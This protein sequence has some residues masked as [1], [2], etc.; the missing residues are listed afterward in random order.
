MSVTVSQLGSVQVGRVYFREL[1][2]PLGRDAYQFDPSSQGKLLQPRSQPIVDDDCIGIESGPGDAG[3]ELS[4]SF[5]HGS[6]DVDHWG[7]FCE[8]EFV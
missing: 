5:L 8:L 6:D 2:F 1:D 3:I 7:H 4:S